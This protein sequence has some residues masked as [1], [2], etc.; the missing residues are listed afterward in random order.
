MSG[1]H[2]LPDVCPFCS[3][4]VRLTGTRTGHRWCCVSCDA[5]VDCYVGTVRPRGTLANAPMRIARTQAQ[6]AIDA[7]WMHR[8]RRTGKRAMAKAQ[9]YEWLA[10]SLGI[11]PRDCDVAR[12]T[13]AQCEHTLTACRPHL[14][15]LREGA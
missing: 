12:F 11:A 8:A 1:R 3:C 10:D 2:K 5:H 7:L 15:K 9:A 6:D 14:D 13:L 4:A